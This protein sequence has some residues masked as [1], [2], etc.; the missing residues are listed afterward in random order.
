M[1]GYLAFLGF[2]VESLGFGD[3]GWVWG[4][5]WFKKMSY[6]CKASFIGVTYG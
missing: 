6:P 3:G 1:L 5:F 2:R 4:S